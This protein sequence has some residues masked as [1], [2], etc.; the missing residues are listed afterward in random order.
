MVLA[1]LAVDRK[2][3]TATGLAF[4]LVLMPVRQGQ[5]LSRCIA[6]R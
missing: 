4:A 1:S 6:R 2:V 5:V 3:G